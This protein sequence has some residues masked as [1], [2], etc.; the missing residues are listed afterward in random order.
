MN[1]TTS[2]AFT[3]LSMNF[4]MPMA[5]LLLVVAGMHE[6]AT[7]LT[8]VL[9][10]LQTGAGM[11]PDLENRAIQRQTQGS[12]AINVGSRQSAASGRSA[13]RQAGLKGERMELAAHFALQGVIDELVLL[14][15]RLAPER[16]GDHGG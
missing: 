6:A 2:L 13:C 16:F 14:D 3:S 4:S 15:P 7:H 1:S 9:T 11:F 5:D 8:A 10:A 12:F